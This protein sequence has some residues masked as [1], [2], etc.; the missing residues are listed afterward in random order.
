M[1]LST[2]RGGNGNHVYSIQMRK[3]GQ[4][5]SLFWKSKLFSW[6]CFASSLLTHVNACRI[7][8]RVRIISAQPLLRDVR[9][10]SEVALQ[11]NST[12]NIKF[13]EQLFFK[14]T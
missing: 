6:K 2:S 3:V 7:Y 4:V 11:F 12:G 10:F 13:R 14:L 8:D 1:K 5:L 9:V